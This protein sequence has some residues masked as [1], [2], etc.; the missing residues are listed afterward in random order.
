MSEES[1]DRK[2]AGSRKPAG[3]PTPAQSRS[4][5]DERVKIGIMTAAGVLLIAIAAVIVILRSGGEEELP[6][7]SAGSAEVKDVQL[8]K[9]EEVLE[10]GKP[11]RVVMETTEG[12]FT[13]DLD[14]ARA[15]VTAN[16]FAYLAESG[17]YDNLG[18]H[19]IVPGFV[20]QG[21]D[22]QGTGTG[23]PGYKLVEAPPKD[24]E[25]K[26]GTVAMAKAGNESAGTSGSQF[27][28]VT[29]PGGASLDPDYALVGRVAAGMDVVEKIG[30]LGGPDERPLKSVL[31]TSA[32]LEQG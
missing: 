30:E 26:P 18:F 3:N 24:L 2:P 4:G 1:K 20:I 8:K 21:G 11:A 12:E 13:I 10:P 32:I 31:I 27:F 15:P 29:G 9:P 23:G 22:P 7:A 16:N 14:T 28:I 25:Y 19:R 5:M 17:F 6:P